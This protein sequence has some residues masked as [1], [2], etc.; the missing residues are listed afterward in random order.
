MI[1]CAPS[2]GGMRA[3]RNPHLPRP[4]LI[5]LTYKCRPPTVHT[6]PTLL[7]TDLHKLLVILGYVIGRLRGGVRSILLKCFKVIKFIYSEKAY[8]I[9]RNLPLTFD[10]MYN[11]SQK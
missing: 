5:L 3:Q 1:H 8:K 10:F 9:L 7:V 6:P 2:C 11:S 4:Q